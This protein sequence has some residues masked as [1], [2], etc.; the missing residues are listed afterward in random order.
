MSENAAGSAP[1]I[2]PEVALKLATLRK[3]IDNLDDALIR[4]LAERF[5]LTQQVGELKAQHTLP[6][7]DP[8][9]E[10][11]QITRLRAL[12]ADANLDPDFAEKWFHFVVQEVIQHHRAI[13]NGD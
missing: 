2:A 12:A 13:A 3:S 4:I 11:T 1:E 7:S 9:R 10:A 5:R 8:Q 6:P